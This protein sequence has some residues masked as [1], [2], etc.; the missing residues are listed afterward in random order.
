MWRPEVWKMH[1]RIM[2]KKNMLIFLMV[3]IRSFKQKIAKIIFQALTDASTDQKKGRRPTELKILCEIAASIKANE[4]QV[5]EVINHFRHTETSFIMPPSNTPLYPEL[6]MDISHESLMRQWSRLRD[7][8]KDEAENTTMVTTLV[9]SQKRKEE[10]KKEYLEGKELR[11]ISDWYDTFKPQTAWAKR[12]S[13]DFKKSFKYLK[14]SKEKRRNK[15]WIL[16]AVITVASIVGL[17]FA[18]Y[19]IRGQADKK[20]RNDAYLN[21]MLS[22]NKNAIQNDN[23][24]QALFFTSEALLLSNDQSEIDSLFRDAKTKKLLPSYSLK[25]IFFASSDV[26]KA[27]IGASNE[28]IFIWGK[29]TFSELNAETGTVKQS[30][31][32]KVVNDDWLGP[33]INQTKLELTFDS[34]PKPVSKDTVLTDSSQY[35]KREFIN[36]F[37]RDNAGF[38]SLPQK[39]QYIDGSSYSLDMKQILTWG[40]NTES[41]FDAVDI[42]DDE[43]NSEGNSLIHRYISG[44]V[45]SNDKRF[46]LTWGSDSTVRL[47]EKQHLT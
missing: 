27:S 21:L 41:K 2:R 34:A 6:V 35:F 24:L 36:I 22:L 44:A 38:I 14:E 30:G 31:K 5:Y 37:E 7:W 10:G 25:N 29:N 32:Y 45:F 33:L 9:S 16:A 46:I 17:F 47:W 20:A 43:G 18:F 39:I 28:T 11:I 12:V 40:Q 1:W 3:E 8:V 4:Q 13:P 19:F 42:W 23:K 26:K 15:I